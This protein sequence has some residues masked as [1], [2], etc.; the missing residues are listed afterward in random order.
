MQNCNY[1]ILLKWLFNFWFRKVHYYS[2]NLLQTIKLFFSGWR[3][4]LQITAEH[5]FV[6]CIWTGDC[7]ELSNYPVHTL[8]GN[9]SSCEISHV[10]CVFLACPPDW[11]WR[12]PPSQRCR[13]CVGYGVCCCLVTGQLYPSC[14]FSSADYQCFQVSN[15]CWEIPS[16]AFI[17]Q[18]LWLIV[19]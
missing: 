2:N 14:G 6:W 3:D 10:D 9:V 4:W 17:H 5:D 7:S 16:T 13:C 12:P 18:V 8:M 15:A 1:I 11:T 19:F